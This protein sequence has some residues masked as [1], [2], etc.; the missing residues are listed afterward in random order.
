MARAECHASTPSVSGAASPTTSTTKSVLPTI[1]PIRRATA[2]ARPSPTRSRKA[3]SRRSWRRSICASRRL[4][5]AIGVQGGHQE[6]TAPSPDDAGLWDPNTNR[7]I[8]G[9]MFNEF[10]FSDTTK[11]QLAGR[12][13]R[14]DLSRDRAQLRRCRHDDLD[15]D[16]ARL[17][18]EERER[19]ADPELCLGSR[20]Q[21]HGAICRARAEAGGAV[22]RRR[23]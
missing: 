3:A 12:I 15:A 6:L 22:L 13:E 11:A 9:Y 20:R 2:C 8:A 17:H 23:P 10:K 18:A 4:T 5:T 1:R 16:L 21:H 14:V 19:R 7:R